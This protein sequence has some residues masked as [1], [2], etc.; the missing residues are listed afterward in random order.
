MDIP[1]TS[2]RAPDRLPVFITIA[3]RAQSLSLDV[4]P[5]TALLAGGD[6]THE[7]RAAKLA[8]AGVHAGNDG[9]SL[10]LLSAEGTEI[11]GPRRMCASS[12][13][14]R[15]FAAALVDR[16]GAHLRL[17]ISATPSGLEGLAGQCALT[18]VAID[19]P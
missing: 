14:W 13:F 7:E 10:A 1:V 8:A 4:R 15:P 9:W 17:A 5:L 16:F 2:R 6:L 19:L 11:V 12:D 18:L 3:G